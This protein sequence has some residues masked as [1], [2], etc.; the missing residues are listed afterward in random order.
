MFFKRKRKEKPKRGSWLRRLL[1]AA[2]VLVVALA[3]VLVYVLQANR[4]PQP[5]I[6]VVAMEG[7]ISFSGSAG[8]NA[9]SY[10]QGYGSRENPETAEQ[11]RDSLKMAGVVV[12]E[13]TVQDDLV[14]YRACGDEVTPVY[15]TC[16]LLQIEIYIDSND[17]SEREL[18]SRIAEVLDV[19]VAQTNCT[20]TDLLQIDFK[21][22]SNRTLTWQM[23]YNEA[24]EAYTHGMSGEGLY[25]AVGQ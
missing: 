13:V 6:D 20:P 15:L 4:V 19:L 25:N 11:M 5:E 22:P 3:G 9:C 2:L 24:S 8:I 12:G 18:G 21:T 16:S 23:G 10:S 1:I 14:E 7:S 17:P